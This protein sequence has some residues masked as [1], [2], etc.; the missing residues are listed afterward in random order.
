M[1]DTPKLSI[2]LGLGQS[3][4]ERGKAQGR[5]TDP[6]AENRQLGSNHKVAQGK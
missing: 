1:A 6:G 2:G 4:K 5:L 3:G